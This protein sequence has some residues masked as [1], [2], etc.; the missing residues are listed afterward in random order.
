M[1]LAGAL[2]SPSAATSPAGT[3]ITIDNFTFGPNVLTVKAGTTV[4]WVNRDDIP[5][6]ILDKDRKVFRSKVL[7]T[8]DSFSF[9]FS[10]P[11]TYDYFCGLHPHM[12]G[13][14]VVTPE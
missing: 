2:S 5:H 4:T 11:G 14:V 7:D 8:E 6:T 13:H 9:T 12:T 3:T 1:G 10:Q